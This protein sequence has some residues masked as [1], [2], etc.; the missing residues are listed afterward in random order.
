MNQLNEKISGG[1]PR[2]KPFN[3]RAKVKVVMLIIEIANGGSNNPFK[4]A[5]IEI[6][7]KPFQW[8]TN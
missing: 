7:G 3:T 5:R 6:G 1:S 4:W 2:S 8:L